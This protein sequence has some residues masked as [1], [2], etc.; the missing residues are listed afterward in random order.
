MRKTLAAIACVA[1]LLPIDAKNTALTDKQAA[2]LANRRICVN[3][4]TTTLPGYVITTWWRNGRP[5]TKGPAVVTNALKAVV[6][7]EQ[8]N[9]LHA[10]AE[11]WRDRAATFSNKVVNVT[12]AIDEKRAEYVQK[13][14]AAALPTTKAIY[15]A[16]IDAL[17]R[18]K[19]KL[20]GGAANE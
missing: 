13:R 6:G 5:D 9:P 20:G 12:A 3:R 17:D 16:M 1:A 11:M 8:S 18:L 2:F 7:R 15:Q 19:E 10:L 4:D 14:D